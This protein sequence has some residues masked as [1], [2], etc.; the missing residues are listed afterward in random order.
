MAMTIAE[1]TMVP[2]LAC[3]NTAPP[4]LLPQ[5]VGALSVAVTAWQLDNPPDPARLRLIAYNPATVKP[6]RNP[7][8]AVRNATTYLA[9]RVLDAKWAASLTADPKIVIL[10][11]IIERELNN[12]GKIISDLL[13]DARERE[14][15]LQPCPLRPLVE[16]A[17]TADPST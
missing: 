11:G 17:Q 1:H 6:L 16:E 12:S 5:V 4:D 7:L 14:L 15:V 3:L 8:A 10:F 13:D 2:T 9:K